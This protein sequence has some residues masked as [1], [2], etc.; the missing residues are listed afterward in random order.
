LQILGRN[1]APIL[2]ALAWY[3]GNSGV[4]YT[5]QGW[6]SKW[7]EKQ[8]EFSVAGPH[9]VAQKRANAWGMKDMLGNVCE[10][11]GD[12]YAPYPGG[13]AIRDPEGPPQAAFRVLRGGSWSEVARACRAAYRGSL[14]PRVCLNTVGFR[15]AIVPSDN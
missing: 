1:N 5:G 10:W 15:L 11:C 3:G 13:G 14:D 12:W 6:T 9:S 8:Y 2:N 7:I 4:G